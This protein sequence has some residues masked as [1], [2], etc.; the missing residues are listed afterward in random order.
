MNNERKILFNYL[1]TIINMQLEN[2]MFL[3]IMTSRH[4]T[5]VKSP[6]KFI[7]AGFKQIKH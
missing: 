3:R 4:M 7:Y 2:Y 6:S 1:A 5:V